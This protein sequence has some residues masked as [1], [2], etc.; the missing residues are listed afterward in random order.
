MKFCVHYVLDDVK[1]S[2]NK[3]IIRE[4]EGKKYF[5]EK[6]TYVHGR[7]TITRKLTRQYDGLE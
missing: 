3:N 1:T 7:I 2:A 5:W 4:H 6:G